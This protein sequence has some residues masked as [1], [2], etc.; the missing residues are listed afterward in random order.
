MSKKENAAM[1]AAVFLFWFSVYTYPS[2]L[3]DYCMQH[4]GAGAFMVGMITGSYGFTQML[5]RIPLGILSDAVK[6]R[7]LFVMLGFGISALSA[8]G[9]LLV[10]G[11]RGNAAAVAALVF[12]GMAGVACSTWVTFSV[13]Y[14]ASYRREEVPAAMSR[15]MLPQFGSQVVAMLLGSQMAQRMGAASAFLMALASAILGIIALS[16]VRDVPPE[17]GP[18]TLRSVAK[19]AMDRDLMLGTVLS[20]VM[21]LVVWATV[22]GFVQNWARD[23]LQLSTG[24]LGYLSVM[25]LVPNTLLSRF[26]GDHLTRRFGRRA[27]LMTGFFAMALACALYP[28]TVDLWSLMGAQAL[29]GAGIGLILPLTM[30]AAIQNIPGDKRSTAMGVH[31]AVY[32]VGMFLGPVL[33]GAIVAGGTVLQ[34]GVMVATGGYIANFY[35]CFAISLAGAAMTFLSFRKKG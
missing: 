25:Y 24:E 19:I 16:Q 12:R 11:M 15:L 1:L 3:Q 22:L 9:F 17:G 10:D 29:M 27:V 21:H 28:H 18:L 5:L 7:K 2:F 23:V 13:L 4:L 30:S 34:D 8:A 35:V 31:Q 32:G 14:T 26:S 20:M 6:K 33:A